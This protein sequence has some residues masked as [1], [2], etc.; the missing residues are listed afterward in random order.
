[1][2]KFCERFLLSVLL[3]LLCGV[4][5][6]ALDVNDFTFKHLTHSDGLCSQRIYSITQT[7]DGAIWWAAKNCVERYNG[8][9]VRCYKLNAPED[10]SYQAGRYIKLFHSASGDLYAFDNKGKI[11]LYDSLSDKFDL[12]A[13]VRP[14]LGETLILNDIY[15]DGESVWLAEGNGI[16]MM[17]NG[18]LPVRK[19]GVVANSI[20]MAGGKL[21]FCTN[22]GLFE[23]VENSQGEVFFKCLVQSNIVSGFYDDAGDR[24]WLGCFT[25]G[26]KVVSFANNGK[27][28]SVAAVNVPVSGVCNPVRSICAY[29]NESV[30]VGVDGM[31]VLKA[32][33]NPL[34]GGSYN[35]DVLFDANDGIKGVLHGNGVYSVIC[36]SWGNVVVGSYSGGIDIAHPV[37]M[38]SKVFRHQYNNRQSVLND[39]VNCVV[40]TSDNRLV[41]GTDNGVSIY[42]TGRDEWVHSA[43]GYVVIDLCVLADGRLLASTYGAGVLE[44]FPDGR[45]RQLYSV[46]NGVLKDNHAYRIFEDRNRC[47]WVGCLDGDLVKISKGK[48]EYFNIRNVKDIVQLPDGRVA[49]GTVNG[50]F[51]IDSRTSEVSSLLYKSPDGSDDVSRYVCTMHLHDGNYLWIGTDGGGIYVYDM[52]DGTTRQLQVGD[53]LP[54]NTIASICADVYGRIMIATDYGLAYVD[55]EYSDRAVNVNYG[56]DVDREYVGL[57]VANLSDGQILYGTTTGALIINPENLKGIDYV[58]KLRLLNV[59][60]SDRHEDF[61]GVLA[62]VRQGDPLELKYDQRT[63]ELSFECIN[64]RNQDDILYQY[65]VGN[66]EWSVQSP[67]QYIRFTNLEPGRHDLCLRSVSRSCGVVLDE[68][69]VEIIV[70]RPWWSSWWMWVIYSLVIVLAFYGSWYFYRLHTE[71]MRLAVNNPSLVSVPLPGK[72]IVETMRSKSAPPK[73]D[74]K[75]FVAKATD[76]IVQYISDSNFTIDALCHEMAMSRTMFY[77]KLKTYTGKSPQDFIKV[78]RLERAAALLRS[79]HSVSEAADMTGFDNPKY[80]STVFKK[81]FKISPSKY[82]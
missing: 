69:D 25:D 49:V 8:V 15:V 13:D 50:I 59:Y 63:F 55:E 65:K 10:V 17:R 70:A 81:Y 38:T 78:I 30:L 72:R 32:T 34:G 67:V 58:A 73:D 28:S 62:G 16:Y 9:V 2:R 6:I 48:R 22:E 56:Y 26:V 4:Q 3:C 42:N 20:V 27:V 33:R 19:I 64:L 31:G 39:H 76:L 35:A 79:G 53:G 51:C 18:E 1:M 61:S 82:R 45:Y 24:L 36:D 66:G 43:E 46:E 12:F 71:Y 37:G 21:C 29:D 57:A 14:V 80:F 74:G 23:C 60:C 54:S 47:L 77:L 44:I 40:Q 75:E 68:L 7:G 41:M 5:A 52:E 11:F